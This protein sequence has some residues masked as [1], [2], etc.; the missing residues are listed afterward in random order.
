MEKKVNIARLEWHRLNP[1]QGTNTPVFSAQYRHQ[2]FQLAR[3]CRDSLDAANN[4]LAGGVTQHRKHPQPVEFLG[5]RTTPSSTSSRI[6]RSNDAFRRGESQNG[7]IL[8]SPDVSSRGNDFVE[9]AINA[10]GHFNKFDHFNDP[11]GEHDFGQVK[12]GETVLSW[13]IEY[14]DNE[15]RQHSRDATSDNQTVRLLLVATA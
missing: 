9:A 6:S 3:R 13:R 2:L 14:L 11:H 7:M 1:Q 12:I 8:V 5:W 15:L 4:S 10:I